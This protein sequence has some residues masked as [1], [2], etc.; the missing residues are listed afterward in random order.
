[1]GNSYQ[2]RFILPAVPAL[3]L[4]TA[5]S[6]HRQKRWAQWTAAVLLAYELL[7]GILNTVVFK[8]ADVFSP[9]QFLIELMS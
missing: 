8:L 7:T 4:L 3:A 2:T 6:L 9:F 5:A 1:M